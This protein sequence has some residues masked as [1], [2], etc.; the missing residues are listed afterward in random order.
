MSLRAHLAGSP[1]GGASARRSSPGRPDW[2]RVIRPPSHVACYAALTAAGLPPARLHGASPAPA[3]PTSP[4]RPD[5]MGGG[6]APRTA[7]ARRPE[8]GP[9]VGRRRCSLSPAACSVATQITGEELSFM[10]EG[11]LRSAPSIAGQGQPRDADERRRDGYRHA[12]FQVLKKTEL[13]PSAA[14]VLDDDQIRHRPQHGQIAR[15]CAR[16]CQG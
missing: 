2:G 4:E 5:G 6:S 14:R 8:V 13:C 1:G 15:Q 9:C 11:P 12:H 10:V 3:W 7:Y 16:H